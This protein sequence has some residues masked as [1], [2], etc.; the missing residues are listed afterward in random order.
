VARR[1]DAADQDS[2]DFAEME[3][4]MQRKNLYLEEWSTSPETMATQPM[5]LGWGA[6]QLMASSTMAYNH[7][8]EQDPKTVEIP[9][10]QEAQ[11]REQTSVDLVILE[12]V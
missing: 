6:S 4:G 12:D 2:E 5:A 11:L 1:S 7:A 10:V 3:T 9:N 8:E